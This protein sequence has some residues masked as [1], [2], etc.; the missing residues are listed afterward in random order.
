MYIKNI[1]FTQHQRNTDTLKRIRKGNP[2]LILVNVLLNKRDLACGQTP[3][4]QK[5]VVN[6]LTKVRVL[7]FNSA[8]D[9]T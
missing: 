6:H 3:A 4:M 1:T 9:V 2:I 8:F 5:D 7:M